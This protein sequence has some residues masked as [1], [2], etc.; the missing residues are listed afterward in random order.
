M[1][2]LAFGIVLITFSTLGAVI[3]SLLINRHRSAL[4]T[5]MVKWWTMIHDT[6]IPALPALAASRVLKLGRTVFPRKLLSWQAALAVI[7]I[8]WCLTTIA[9]L[10]GCIIDG[11]PWHSLPSRLPI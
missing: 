10:I 8:S 6:P 3:D 5:A 2:L 4:H 11:D 1:V 9:F 7:L